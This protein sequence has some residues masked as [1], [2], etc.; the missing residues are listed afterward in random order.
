[1]VRKVAT[2][3]A[4][5]HKAKAFRTETQCHD[6]VGLFR[7]AEK[8]LLD[9]FKD[10]SEESQSK[11]R[12][13][14]VEHCTDEEKADETLNKIYKRVPSVWEESTTLVSSTSRAL[15]VD[16]NFLA[17]RSPSSESGVLTIKAWIAKIASLLDK[18]PEEAAW[19]I[20]WPDFPEVSK[21]PPPN[22]A[23]T[24]RELIPSRT[25]LGNNWTNLLGS[26]FTIDKTPPA[27][28]L[29]TAALAANPVTQ[30][31]PDGSPEQPSALP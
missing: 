16:S 20:W 15:M 8:D 10:P 27:A 17:W 9:P 11:Q 29:I 4:L 6:E 13:K 19:K 2:P 22:L 31:H 30:G 7:V 18:A 23:L 14:E 12:S 21:V 28:A 5:Q 24:H 25:A 26:N 1:M 3:K